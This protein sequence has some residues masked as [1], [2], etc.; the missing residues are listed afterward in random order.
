M[1][2]LYPRLDDAGMKEQ[3]I[4][5]YAQRQEPERVDRLIEIIEA[6]EDPELRKRAI[7]WLGQTGDERAIEFLLNLVD[8]PPR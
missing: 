5:L 7:F 6:E 4:F 3:L 1:D 8:D 2:G